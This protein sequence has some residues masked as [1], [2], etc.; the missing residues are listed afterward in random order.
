M[1]LTVQN[2][3]DSVDERTIYQHYFPQ[4]IDLRRNK[5][6]NPFRCD[7]KTGSCHFA[8]YK[9]R[10]YFFDKSLNKGYDVFS[11]IQHR[12]R[13]SFYESLYIVNRDF[14]L[15][16][17][18]SP[19]KIRSHLLSSAARKARIVKPRKI[20]YNSSRRVYFN[21]DVRS[22]NV[23]DEQ[24]WLSYGIPKSLLNQY[25][26]K[27]V[28]TYKVNYRGN[29]WIPAYRHTS[30]DPCYLYQTKWN[31]KTQIKIYRPF[32]K[33]EKWRSS[34]ETSTLFGYEQLPKTGKLLFISSSLKDG[35]CL[36]KLGYDFVAPLSESTPIDAKTIKELKARFKR[37]IILFDRDET[38]LKY[39]SLFAKAYGVERMI[40][41]YYR[42]ARKIKD[43]ADVAKYI[44]YRY[45]NKAIKDYLDG[46]VSRKKNLT[47]VGRRITSKLRIPILKC[48][49]AASVALI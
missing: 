48:Y 5:Y 7:R 8:Y 3:L 43:V 33:E 45:I 13:C 41:P 40:L 38:G 32:S 23:F 29:S 19:T 22:W 36:K 15:N 9:R 46:N 30:D 18:Y 35:L 34:C 20:E 28:R 14:G 16:L 25:N 17:I 21:I 49:R 42:H 44:G 10:L 27:P 26:I 2:I 1:F 12:Y 31:N 4:R 11:F 37:I 24:Y 6:L 39:S 47:R